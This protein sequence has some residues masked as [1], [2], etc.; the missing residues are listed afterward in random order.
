MR[1]TVLITLI[2]AGILSTFAA[3]AFETRDE[4]REAYQSIAQVEEV[5]ATEP[6]INPPYV[7]GTLSDSAKQNA[8]D[9]VNFLRGVAHLNPV[10]E[11]AL[12][13]LR[14]GN[15]A[16]LLAK[17]DYVDHDPPQPADMPDEFYAS[18]HEGASQGNLAGMNWM[19]NTVLAEGIRYFVRDDGATNLSLLGHRRWILNPRMGET[20]FGLANSASGRSYVVMYALD[21][22]ADCEW[23]EVC[24]PSA[25]AF[26]AELMHADLAW[27]ITLNAEIY[28]IENANPVITLAEERLGL[29]FTFDCRNETGDG[30]CRISMENFGSGACLIFCPDFTETDFTDYSQNQRWTVH[31]AGLCG[32]KSEIAYTVNMQSLYV[33]D[34][35][36]VEMRENAMEMTVGETVQLFAN[37]VPEYADDL[38]LSWSS[39]DSNVASVDSN[40]TVTAL[41]EGSCEIAAKS[42][43]GRADYCQ[44]SV[45]NGN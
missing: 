4:L 6:S 32:K 9:T 45:S 40:G 8:L 3:Q 31:V 25:G 34:V 19:R 29:T 2:V 36:N 35:S 37:V 18:A 28:D 43:N 26:P 42:E 22:S 23:S 21:E 13:D 11:N 39:S 10:N 27:S 5:F 20:G 1:K 15:A 41:S 14:C 33:Q 7:A 16:V 24:W 44:I 38:T 30:Y 17:N 12:Y